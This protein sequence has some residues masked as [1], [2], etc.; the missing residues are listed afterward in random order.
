MKKMKKLISA[1]ALLLTAVMLFPAAMLSCSSGI[2]DPIGEE[3]V[4]EW[5]PLL[6]VEE[7]EAIFGKVTGHNAT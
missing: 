2:E 6:S 7:A 3:E 5:A 4:K 1:L